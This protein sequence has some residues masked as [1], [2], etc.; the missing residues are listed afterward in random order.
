MKH[1]DNPKSIKFYVKNFLYRERSRFEGKKVLDFPAGNGVTSNI[2]KDIGATPL[3]YDLFPEFFNVDNLTCLKA[4]INDCIPLENE[5][6]DM[7]LCQE[8]IEHFEDQLKSLREFNRVLRGGG[9]IITTPN[10]SNMIGRISYFLSESELFKYMP[11]N[12]LDDIWLTNQGKSTEIYYGH[13]F[14]IGINKLRLLA[15]ISGFKIKNIEK[16][17]VK[18]SAVILLLLFYPIIFLSNWVSYIKKLMKNKQFPYKV[19]KEVYGDI[20]KLAINPRLLVNSHIFIEFEKEFSTEE[21]KK[22]LSS[23]KR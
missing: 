4:N 5:S 14:L 18:R 22:Q 1:E 20:F 23:R 13:L 3:P 19:K 2:L 9:L 10:Y 7:I 16:T 6:I 12:E 17:K 21:A 11:Q 15:K 8:G